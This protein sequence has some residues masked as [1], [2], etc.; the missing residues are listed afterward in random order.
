MKR[1]TRIVRHALVSAVALGCGDSGSPSQPGGPASGRP[2]A[3]NAIAAGTLSSCMLTDTGDSYCWGWNSVGQLGT[4]DT[5]SSTV[6]RPTSGGLHFLQITAGTYFACAVTTADLAYC[7]GL[8]TAGQ[9]GSG[10]TTSSLTPAPVA[11][12]LK[13]QSVSA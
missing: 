5:V 8:G 9:L 3:V 12:G 11:G 1:A 13:F 6:P 7:W 10:S 4:G 2:D